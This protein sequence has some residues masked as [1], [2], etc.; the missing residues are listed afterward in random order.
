M[1]VQEDAMNDNSTEPARLDLHS[2]DIVEDKR[3][4][5]GWVRRT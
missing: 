1:T 3:E 5:R 4:A 2:H